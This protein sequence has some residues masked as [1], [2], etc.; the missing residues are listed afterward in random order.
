[1]CYNVTILLIV[2]Y[3][4]HKIKNTFSSRKLYITN[5]EEEMVVPAD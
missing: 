1:M 3:P 2:I 4:S 5:K